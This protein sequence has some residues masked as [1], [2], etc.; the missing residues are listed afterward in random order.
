[1]AG[2]Q[3]AGQ[4]VEQFC[5]AIHDFLMFYQHQIN[6]IASKVLVRR[7]HEAAQFFNNQ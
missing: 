3:V 7:Q 1:M 5:F 4:M 2:Q 6:D